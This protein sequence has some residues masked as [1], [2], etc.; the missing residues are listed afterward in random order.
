MDLKHFVYASDHRSA[1]QRGHQA[2]KLIGLWH[3]IKPAVLP[4]DQQVK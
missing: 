2:L 3:S 1:S 4:L